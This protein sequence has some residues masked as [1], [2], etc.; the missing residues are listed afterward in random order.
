MVPIPKKYIKEIRSGKFPKETKEY[1]VNMVSNSEKLH[2]TNCK[3][4]NSSIS[5]SQYIDF[6]D[7]DEAFKF[8]K[9]YQDVSI[10]LKN[11]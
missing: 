5:A 2:I 1:F 7:V 10:V 9:I 8:F 4:C 11:N 6:A 3:N